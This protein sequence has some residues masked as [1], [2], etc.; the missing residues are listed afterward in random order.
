M[1]KACAVELTEKETSM[2]HGELTNRVDSSFPECFRCGK[3]NHVPDQC[4]YHKSKGLIAWE[5]FSAAYGVEK[6]PDYMKC[7]LD[8]K[9]KSEVNLG[10]NLSVASVVLAIYIFPRLSISLG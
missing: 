3:S 6:S 7:Q 5:N 4:F 9:L 1:E 2:L 8:L 10:T